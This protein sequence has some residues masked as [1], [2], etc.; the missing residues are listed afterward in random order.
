MVLRSRPLSPHLQVYKLPVAAL[1]SITHRASGLFLFFGLS[2]L[3]W[4]FV[5]L[6]CAP[7]CI[8]PFLA[9]PL[10]FF[11]VKLLSFSCCVAFCYHYFN[12]VRHLLWDCGVGLDKTAV[13]ASSAFVLLLT[14]AFSVVA[15]FFVWL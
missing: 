15:F 6:R 1:L 11:L 8:A 5:L 4:L 2:V 12:G 14:A 7:D 10:G 9:N 3:S 13:T